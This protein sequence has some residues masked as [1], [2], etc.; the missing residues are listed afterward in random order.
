[1]VKNWIAFILLT[2]PDHHF[3]LAK[4]ALEYGVHV[5]LEKPMCV[6]THEADELIALANNKG[7]F[8]GVNHNFC[9]SD[10]YVRLRNALSSGSLGPIDHL[11]FIY[12]YE[13]P[14]IRNGPFDS[15]MLRNP[16][17][18]ILETGPHFVSAL[19][20]L[21]GSPEQPVVSADRL[22]R[23]PQWPAGH[24]AVGVFALVRNEQ[25]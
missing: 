24:L 21:I 15:W 18:V 3:R 23:L 5:F 4:V 9:F 12:L 19:F 17:N 7:L 10:A 22:I 13:L 1:M 11:T 16:G 14:Q 2:P 8:L 25:P 20:D 6:S